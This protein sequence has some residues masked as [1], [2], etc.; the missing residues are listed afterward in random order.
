MF[1]LTLPQSLTEN[2]DTLDAELTEAALEIEEGHSFFQPS[3]DYT[4][5]AVNLAKKNAF[6]LDIDATKQA[7]LENVSHGKFD[8][9]EFSG[10]R[11]LTPA[12]AE[13]IYSRIQ[14]PAVNASI[15]IVHNEVVIKPHRVG[16]LVNK[17]LLLSHLKNKEMQF[18]LPVTAVMPRLTTDHFSVNMFADILGEYKSPYDESNADRTQNVVL[19]A[20][21][22]NG[23]IIAPGKTFSFNEVVG[24]RNTKRGFKRPQEYSGGGEDDG[25]GG[26]ISQVSSTLYCVQLFADLE[27]VS[28]KNHEFAVNYVPEG[29]DANSIYGTVDYSFKNTTD[30]PIKI[31][32]ITRDGELIVRILGTKEDKSREINIINQV[33]ET[34]PYTTVE[35]QTNTLP[36]GAT[37]V[38]Q[39]GAEGKKVDTY[40]VYI[41]DGIE[42]YREFVHSS[43]YKP[44]NQINLFGGR[45]STAADV[46]GTPEP[47]Q[48]PATPEPPAETQQ[49][50]PEE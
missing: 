38:K 46:F 37:M 13:L 21:L 42:E 3:Q 24:E 12:D 6:M 18:T 26:G 28:R 23:V 48:Q 22:I 15:E 34:K 4:S 33:V 25:V 20:S 14:S 11:T 1:L 50:E 49:P 7:I 47:T 41:K 31:E 40:K 9:V 5:I 39:Y 35:Q 16:I 29:M 19:T 27:T 2:G 8:P 43:V 45:D 44:V 32:A 17:D 10:K 36:E 30:Y